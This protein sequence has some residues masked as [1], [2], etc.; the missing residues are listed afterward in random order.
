MYAH[1]PVARRRKW[2]PGSVSPPSLTSPPCSA[3]AAIT[4]GTARSLETASPQPS[5]LPRKTSTCSKKREEKHS[6]CPQRTTTS[7]NSRLSK[8]GGKHNGMEKQEKARQD[9]R[10]KDKRRRN[11]WGAIGKR[12]VV[13]R[14]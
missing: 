5:S 12:A 13:H 10:C 6:M 8:T 2:P 9:S 1:Y 11:R 14:G 4:E 3:V 7:Q